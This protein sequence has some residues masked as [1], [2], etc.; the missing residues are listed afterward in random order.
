MKDYLIFI[1]I[2]IGLASEVRW[3]SNT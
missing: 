2:W 3:K 1:L